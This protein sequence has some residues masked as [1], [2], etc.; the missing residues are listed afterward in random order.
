MAERVLMQCKKPFSAVIGGRRVVVAVGDLYYSD[1][2]VL[3]GRERLFGELAIK[4]ST[5][6]PS[7]RSNAAVETAT[8]D[9]GA[10]RARTRPQPVEAKPQ[11]AG[12]KVVE[13]KTT[14]KATS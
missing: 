11:D 2:P 6:A 10:R 14:G 3:T 1:D 5:P 13:S 9:P 4:S 8:A 7:A 12:P